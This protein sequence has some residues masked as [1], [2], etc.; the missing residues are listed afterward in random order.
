MTGM[1]NRIRSRQRYVLAY[2]VVLSAT[3]GIVIGAGVPQPWATLIMGM[4]A[5]TAAWIMSRIAC[6]HLHKRLHR[7]REAADALVRGD[8]TTVI[9]HPAG[10]DFVKL[11]DSLER[12]LDQ[13]RESFRE[14]ERLQRQ[15]TRTEKLAL[16]GELAAT[17]AHEVNNPLDGL[18]NST[19]IIRR[20]MDNPEQ[21]RQLLDLMDTGL[22]RIEMIVRRLL[23]MSRDEP[24]SLAPVRVDEI[25]D[26]AL[27][28]VQPKLNRRRIELVRDFPDSHVSPKLTAC[29]WLRC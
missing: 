6:R 16:I 12:V 25:V 15:L 10:D 20:S 4:A 1:L 26:D 14:H 18:Q 11:S 9:D 17:V 5:L 21:V 8:L 13:L 27:M 2:T 19:R 7:L 22:Y 3:A 28:F 24:L 29:R 23:T